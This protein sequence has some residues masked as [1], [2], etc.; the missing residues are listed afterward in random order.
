MLSLT[1]DSYG[2]LGRPVRRNTD[3]FAYDTRGQVTIV[4]KEVF[5]GPDHS[6]TLQGAGGVGGLVAVS[7]DGFY[8]FP[9]YDNLGNIVAYVNESGTKV[10]SYT[11][12]AFG[13]MV[14]S[15]GLMR[16]T[17][18]HRFSTKWQDNE[19]LMYDYGYRW[20]WPEM[21]RWMNRDPIGE[22]GGV[23]LY[24]FCQNNPCRFYDSKGLFTIL[25]CST[26]CGISAQKVDMAFQALIGNGTF[27]RITSNIREP[28]R[29][30]IDPSFTNIPYSLVLHHKQS[31]WG[32]PN[33]N[34][35]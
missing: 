34:T 31:E 3:A 23:N 19:T 29:T 27:E 21:G 1:F 8:Y 22:E 2:L 4:S 13:Y 10:A 33:G 18:P 15:S 12:D 35:D 30:A 9:C 14:S 16:E 7:I 11:Y 24:G 5:W 6:G 20:Y 32:I 17:F 26:G 28:F 25:P